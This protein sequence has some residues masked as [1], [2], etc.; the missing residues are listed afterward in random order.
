MLKGDEGKVAVSYVTDT[1]LDD[2]YKG[3]HRSMPSY[4]AT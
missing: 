3:I 4:Y 2:G 1:K